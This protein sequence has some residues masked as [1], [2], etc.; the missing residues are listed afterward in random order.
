MR[1]AAETVAI[2][3]EISLMPAMVRMPGAGHIRGI[4]RLRPMTNMKAR[5]A[6]GETLFGTFLTLGSPLVAESLA[7]AGVDWLPVDLEHGGGDESLLL[8]QLLGVTAGGAHGLVRV[9]TDARGR[10]ARALDY[11]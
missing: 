8:S 1:R 4:P 3:L 7:V 2:R 5:L 9:E 11:G 10:T 6:A